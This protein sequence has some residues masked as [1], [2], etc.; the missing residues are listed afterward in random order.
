MNGTSSDNN[1]R[2]ASLSK[3]IGQEKLKNV[4]SIAIAGA[5]ARKEPVRHSLFVGPPGLGKTTLAN[6]VATATNRSLITASATSITKVPTLATLLNQ[7][8]EQTNVLFIDEIHRLPRVVEEALYTVM[9]D[10]RLDVTTEKMHINMHLP[11]FTFIG[12]TTRQ[13]LITKPLQDR[14]SATYHLDFYS[15]KELSAVIRQSARV[16]QLDMEDLAVSELA[17]RAKRTPRIANNLLLQSRDFALAYGI[18]QVSYPVVLGMMEALD[19]DQLGLT[20]TDRT[21]LALL[22]ERFNGGP[23]GLDTLA[24]VMIEEPD[25]IERV[26]EPYLLQEH[27]IERTPRGRTATEKAYEHLGKP[28][29]KGAYNSI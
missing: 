1:L 23:V 26:Y 22:I 11:K 4:L 5:N 17:K 20:K 15:I 13:G 24:A 21:I 28:Y 2:P 8:N 10:Y 25:V 6:I 9:E 27:L 7:L 14:F 16:L 12:A 29:T 3:F 18:Q 19:I